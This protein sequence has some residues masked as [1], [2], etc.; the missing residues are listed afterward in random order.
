MDNWYDHGEDSEE[1][2]RR[3]ARDAENR[4]VEYGKKVVKESLFQE[5]KAELA[6]CE[7][8]IDVLLSKEEQS[9]IGINPDDV[10]HTRTLSHRFMRILVAYNEEKE[11]EFKLANYILKHTTDTCNAGVV[12]VNTDIETLRNMAKKVLKGH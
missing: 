11:A 2:K 9:E 12:L 1:L 3:I 7:T 8:H 6:S 4:L 5:M 10:D